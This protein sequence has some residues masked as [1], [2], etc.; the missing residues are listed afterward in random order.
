MPSPGR[1]P[2]LSLGWAHTPGAPTRISAVQSAATRSRSLIL[3]DRNSQPGTQPLSLVSQAFG[4]WKPSDPHPKSFLILPVRVSLLPPPPPQV[5]PAQRRKVPDPRRRSSR[6]G[7][8]SPPPPTS[9][10]VASPTPLL[11][12][13]RYDA[14]KGKVRSQGFWESPRVLTDTSRAPQPYLGVTSFDCFLVRMAN[15]VIAAL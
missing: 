12:D 2:P 3:S 7:P 11:L 9:P 6:R 1:C 14:F 5:P 10:E 8:G 13:L 15:E 4:G